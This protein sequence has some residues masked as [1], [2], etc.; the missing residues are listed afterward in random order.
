MAISQNVEKILV[1]D[2]IILKNQNVV[3]CKVNVEED[4]IQNVLSI[5]GKTHL[6]KVECGE[7]ELK[8]EG[9]AL[10]T[11]LYKFDGEV[12][13]QE[14]GVEYGFKFYDDKILQG[15]QVD[16]DV[17]LKDCEI[18][19]VNGV[20]QVTATLCF[21]GKIDKQ[22]K[23]E[24]IASCENAVVKNKEMEISSLL[25]TINSEFKIE[26]EE[27]LNYSIKNILQH[28][29]NVVVKSVE[30]GIG[31]A[32]VEGEV[33]IELLVAPLNDSGIVKEMKVVP[34][35]VE[36]ESQDIST[37]TPCSVNCLISESLFKVFVD[38]AKN[39]SVVA[40]EL[41]LITKCKV[42]E[43]KNYTYADD[44]YSL[45]Y[46]LSLVKNNLQ[47]YKINNYVVE[48]QKV[49]GEIPFEEDESLNFIT[50]IRY[51][52]QDISYALEDNKLTITGVL[53]CKALFKN[54]DNEYIIKE[55]ILP[56]TS[57][58][59][60]RNQIEGEVLVNVSNFSCNVVKNAIKYQ[61]ILNVSYLSV[62]KCNNCVIINVLENEKRQKSQSGI[63]VYIPN[64][65]DSLWDVLKALGESE[66]DILKNNPTLEFPLSGDERIIIYREIN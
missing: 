65:G 8:Y 30:C 20:S 62:E 32:I 43:T 2:S 39:K 22:N 61:F 55:S 41:T 48:S 31:V 52:K 66:E 47:T 11:L 54:K 38:E 14:V 6:T 25:K 51:K 34:F 36:I 23:I 7:K 45:D 40:I 42:Y 15:N 46:E 13:S 60:I 27:E 4:A 57:D 19:S 29:E 24:Y 56:F 3:E 9:K 50:C 44:M 53:L 28:T 5:L 37:S 49:N 35:R 10:F 59:V 16:G 18:K 21:L 63:S 17:F 12:K 58:F 26:D 33:E 64:E 1:D